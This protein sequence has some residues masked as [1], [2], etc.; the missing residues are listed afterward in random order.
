MC[1]YCRENKDIWTFCVIYHTYWVLLN[2]YIVGDSSWNRRRRN[3]RKLN[4]CTKLFRMLSQISWEETVLQCCDELNYLPRWRNS[5]LLHFTSFNKKYWWKIQLLHYWTFHHLFI[6]YS[7]TLLLIC[8]GR[9]KFCSGHTKSKLTLYKIDL[10]CSRYSD[11]DWS[12]MDLSTMDSN[13]LPYPFE[14]I[15]TKEY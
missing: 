13:F 4:G 10:T 15:F 6:S 5:S 7:C 14:R 1:M 3:M 8:F 9:I 11:I 2:S 12:P